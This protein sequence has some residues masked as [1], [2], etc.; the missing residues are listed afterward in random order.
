MKKNNIISEWL[1][2]HGDPEIDKLV[3]ENLEKTIKTDMKP[4]PIKEGKT[5]S[6]SKPFTG[7]GRQAPPPPKPPK[8]A[9]NIEITIK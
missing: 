6:N 3:Q 9:I 2:Q 8:R 5:K 7:E 4:Q 1:D